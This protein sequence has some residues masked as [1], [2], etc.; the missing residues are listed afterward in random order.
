MLYNCKDFNLKVCVLI[1]T[2]NE[3]KTIGKLIRDIK[4]IG[5]D[6]FVIDD[7]SQDDTFQIATYSGAIVISNAKNLGKGMSLRRGLDYIKELNYQA[8]I[9]MDGDGQHTS[10]DIPQFIKAA[11]DPEVSIIIGNRMSAAKGMPFLRWFTNKFMSWVISLFC[12]VKIPDS[13]CG[14]RIIK[15]EVLKDIKLRTSKYE[16]ESELL[17]KAAKRGFKIKSIPIKTIYQGQ[18]SQINPILDTL[19]FIRF[20]LKELL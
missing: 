11:K 1:P 19:R 6:I 10:D 17:I 18:S 9:I 7:G 13:Q 20:I 12:R 4:K 16:I 8:V 2:F 15:I 5:L 3:S 14:F